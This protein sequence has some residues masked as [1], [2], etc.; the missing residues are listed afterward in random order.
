M[1]SEVVVIFLY[2]PDDYRREAKKRELIGEFLRKHSGLGLG[3]F[4]LSETEEREKFES[5]VRST[6]LFES[7][8]LAVVSG[9]CS[10]VKQILKSLLETRTVVVLIS[11]SGK[12]AKKDYPFLFKATVTSQEFEILEGVKWK[13]FIKQQALQMGAS[14]DDEVLGFLSKIYEGDTWRLIT[15]LSKISCS[16]KP[17]TMKNIGEYHLEAAPDFWA[18][19]NGLKSPSGKVRLEA[20]ERLFAQNEPS[21]KVFN[22]MASLWKE[23]TPL[24]AEFDIAVKSGKL[25]YEEALMDLAIS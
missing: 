6:S 16:S 2:G 21:A 22:I 19:V 18:L 15:E 20:L 9:I 10:D 11:E 5:F 23:R 25:D 24:F 13:S 17:V 14:C 7:M 3:Y 4:D 8:K 12:V 1:Y